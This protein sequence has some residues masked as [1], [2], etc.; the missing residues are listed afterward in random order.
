[1]YEAAK[2]PIQQ[3]TPAPKSKQNKFPK[4]ESFDCGAVGS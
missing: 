3:N 1:M 4:T 2:K